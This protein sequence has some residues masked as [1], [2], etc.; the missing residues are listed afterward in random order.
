MHEQPVLKRLGFSDDNA[1][2]VSE[3]LARRGFYLPSGLGLSQA[4]IDTVCDEVCALLADFGI[5]T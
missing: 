1:R 2:P 4:E 3:R 5:R